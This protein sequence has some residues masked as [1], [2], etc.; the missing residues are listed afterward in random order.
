[1][2]GD[3]SNW[4]QAVGPRPAYAATEEAAAASA[5]QREVIEAIRECG[6]AARV[7]EIAQAVA[8]HPN[9]V[10]GHLDGLIGAGIVA[11][12]AQGTA[13]RGRPWLK[14]SVR[15][16]HPSQLAGEYIRLIEVL[17]G[18]LCGP[19]SAGRGSAA[20]DRAEE[21]G[22]VWGRGVFEADRSRAAT[23]AENEDPLGAAVGELRKLGFDPHLRDNATVGL[24]ACPFIGAD[25]AAPDATIC[26]IHAGYIRERAGN[27]SV[28]LVSFDRRGECGVVVKLP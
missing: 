21:L 4:D 9:T 17:A 23:W 22:R 3:E 25:G 6:G 8:A 26:H 18:Q 19:D 20:A 15:S 12:E 13:T 10:R 28:D 14:Y 24:R 27:C 5:K 11:A 7:S 16:P 2:V 1:M